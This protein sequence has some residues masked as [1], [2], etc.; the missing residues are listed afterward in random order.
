M[1]ADL[2]TRTEWRTDAN[3]WDGAA[4]AW[5]AG[6]TSENT[7]AVYRAGLRQFIF[8]MRDAEAW[9]AVAGKRGSAGSAPDAALSSIE[10]WCVTISNVE[11]WKT[12]M[13]GAGLSAATI[14]NRLAALSSF[15]EYCRTKIMR[16]NGMTPEALVL[17]NPVDGVDR[18]KLKPRKRVVLTVQ[19]VRALVRHQPATTLAGLRNRAL[20]M[21]YLY[22]GLRNSEIRNLRW[23]DFSVA[24]DGTVRV[25]WTGKGLTGDDR[26]VRPIVLDAVRAYLSAAGKL[27]G[28][29]QDAFVFTPLS[30]D[31]TRFPHVAESNVEAPLSRQRINAIIKACAKR[32]GLNADMITTH[33]LRRTA[34]TSFYEASGYDIELTR[35]MLHHARIETTIRYV[36][37]ES[38]DSDA[39]WQTVEEWFGL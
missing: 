10:P 21:C 19:Q 12:A 37:Q 16:L 27:P 39:V 29:P 13:V 2:R 25:F 14:N 4:S 20:L 33:T 17:V 31:A 38:V 36:N 34:A 32:A 5:L 9:A 22:T 30:D 18:A 8:W 6:V 7:H 26:K 3:V 35:Q 11:R 28:M 15:Y 24:E 23:G 1:V